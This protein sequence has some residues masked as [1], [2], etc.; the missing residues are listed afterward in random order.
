MYANPKVWI[1]D[2]KEASI[3]RGQL[4]QHFAAGRP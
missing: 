2:L 3:V 4:S 1:Q